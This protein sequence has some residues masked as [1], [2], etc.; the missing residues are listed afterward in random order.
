VDLPGGPAI[1]EPNV[2]AHKEEAARCE[3]EAKQLERDL[4]A[5]RRQVEDLERQEAAIRE[6]MLVP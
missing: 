1:R 4:P 6:K 3:A 2:K 5:L